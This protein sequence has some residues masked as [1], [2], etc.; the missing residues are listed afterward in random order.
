MEKVGYGALVDEFDLR[1]V[2]H[3]RSLE[4]SG[5]AR[6]RQL[7]EKGPP[8]TASKPAIGPTPRSRTTYDQHTQP[9]C[10]CTP[11]STN[12]PR[13]TS[14]HSCSQGSD[15]IPLIDPA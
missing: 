12:P 5:A 1:C 14:S 4:I 6:G 7:V 3:Y 8:A 9:A 11:I 15:P 10:Q 13:A 2:P